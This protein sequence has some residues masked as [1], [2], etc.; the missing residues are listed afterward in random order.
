[1][2][3]L[4]LLHVNKLTTIQFISSCDI[5]NS[6]SPENISSPSYGKGGRPSSFQS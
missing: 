6:M 5:K 1:M 4:F 2:N 3:I